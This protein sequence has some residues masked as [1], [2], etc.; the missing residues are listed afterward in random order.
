MD[1]H[2]IKT[3]NLK[4]GAMF[5]ATPHEVYEMLMDSKKHSRFSQDRANI[6]RKIGGKF[7]AYGGWIEGKNLKLVKDKEIVQEWRGKDWPKGHYS[8]VKFMLKKAGNGTKLM[9][10]QDGIPVD[11]YKDISSGWKEFYWERMKE[12]LES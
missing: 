5:K 6:S 10:S 9:F 8:T 4:Q 12:E 11:K 7:T 1:S 2:G 3:K